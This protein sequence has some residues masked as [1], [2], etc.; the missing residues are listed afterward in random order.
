MTDDLGATRMEL[1]GLNTSIPEG[2]A[3]TQFGLDVSLEETK[4]HVLNE[5]G[6]R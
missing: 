5:A 6:R 4:F 3:M 1:G 2:A